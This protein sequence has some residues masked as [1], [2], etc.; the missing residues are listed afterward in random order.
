MFYLHSGTGVQPWLKRNG[1]FQIFAEM[2]LM[3]SGI[4]NVVLSACREFMKPVARLLLKHG[5]GYQEFSE[6]CKSIFVEVASVDYGIRG[7]KTN[8]SRVAVMTGLSRKEVRRVRDSIDT[9]S[10]TFVTRVRRPELVLAIWHSSP[11][12]LDRRQRPKR[13]PFDGP[14]PN[15]RT[16]VM[17]VGG[18]I[19]PKAMLNEL[20]RAGSVVREADKLRVVSRSYVPEPHDPET[21]L[22]A[23]GAIRDLTSTINHNLECKE[24][25]LRYFERRVYSEALPDEQRPRFKK[26]A[27]EKGGV[28]LRDLSAWL[29]ERE[30]PSDEADIESTPAKKTA[31]IGVGVYFFDDLGSS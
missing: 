18:D 1:I 14:G 5:I 19:P 27:R 31:R 15:F 6:L 2:H 17:R 21:I 25:D 26:L 4:K 30:Q 3:T 24:P 12:F 13:I 11:E 9:D 10:S 23:G 29:S 16:L 20:M 28:L 8:M 22:V 7:R